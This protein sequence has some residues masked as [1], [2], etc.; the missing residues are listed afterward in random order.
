M[1]EII[2]NNLGIQ[3]SK[4]FSSAGIASIILIVAAYVL[5]AVN[6]LNYGVDF[7]GGAEITIK[8]GKDIDLDL[9]RTSLKERGFPNASVQALGAADEHSFIVKVLAQE[10]NLNQVTQKIS[11]SL[12]QHFSA[13]GVEIRKTDI[14]G[15]KAG[16]ELRAAGFK[17]MVYA[18]LAIMIY[19][20]L[21]FDFKYAP[22]AV[23]ST[24]HDASFVLGLWSVL[25]LEFSLQ[26]VAAILTV[27]GYSVN[28]TVV[29][30]DRVRE[31]EDKNPGLPMVTV[32]NNAVNETLS[33]T[34]LTAGATLLSSIAMYIW[35]G[36]SIS[37]FF[38]A[39]SIGIVVGTYSSIYIAAPITIFLDKYNIGNNKSANA[40]GSG[41][42]RSTSL[43]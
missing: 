29:I 5:I 28:D 40:G 15:P 16:A 30:Y 4:Y 41:A 37:D 2:K 27:I 39:M 19:I 12:Q 1:I 24:L 6:G 3:F 25:G 20:G 36:A 21:R 17:A 13:Q 34:I 26:T 14:V 31:H 8:F 42:V 33:R 10:S 43:V 32:F 7:R 9:L 23:V 18:M 38:L 22:G 11:E 35:G